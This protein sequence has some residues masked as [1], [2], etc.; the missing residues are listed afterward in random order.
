MGVRWETA[1]MLSKYTKSVKFEDSFIEKIQ[2][3]LKPALTL[4]N[5]LEVS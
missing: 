4:T 1:W 2:S 3:G 5:H